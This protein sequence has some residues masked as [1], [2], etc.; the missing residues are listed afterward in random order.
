MVRAEKINYDDCFMGDR[1]H[2]CLWTIRGRFFQLDP[3]VFS[4]E[5]CMLDGGLFKQFAKDW[6]W[7]VQGE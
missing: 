6:D 4:D 2:V 1:V 3:F 5:D 7:I